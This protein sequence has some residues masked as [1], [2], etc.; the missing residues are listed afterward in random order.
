MVRRE[1]IV[2]SPLPNFSAASAIT[3][4]SSD[5]IFPFL[6]ITRPLNLSGVLLSFRKPSAF[7]LVSSSFDTASSAFFT[8]TSLKNVAPSST[9]VFLYP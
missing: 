7:T 5:V 6:V 2:T 4:A 3:L 1:V 9:T 8:F